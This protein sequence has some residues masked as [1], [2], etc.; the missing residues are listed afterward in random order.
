MTAVRWCWND[1]G[2]PDEEILYRKVLRQEGH[3]AWDAENDCYRPGLAAL[4]RDPN[5][6]LST[7]AGSL[8]EMRGR[9]PETLYDSARYC[10]MYFQAGIPREESNVGIIY[11]EA[12]IEHEPDEDLRFAHA[13]VR[14]ENPEKDKPLWNRVRDNIIRNSSWVGECP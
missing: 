12:E 10:T 2:I 7:H 6:G 14:P 11:V 1:S 9:S 3:L 5:T 13:E 8:L 4:R